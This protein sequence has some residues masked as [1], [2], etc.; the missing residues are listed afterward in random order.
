MKRSE[1]PAFGNMCGIRVI[2]T[3]TNIAGPV[4][5]TFL[6]EQG[7]DV[8]H[9]ESTKSPDMLRRMG[10]AWTQEH[11]NVRSLALNIPSPQ[12]RALFLRLLADADVLIEASKAGQYDKWGLSDETLRTMWA[13]PPLIPSARH[14]AALWGS[15]ERRICPTRPS[16]TPVTSSARCSRR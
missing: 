15:T 5:G 13:A 4:A 12:G 11:R 1:L 14:S 7:A 6:A 16:P 3:G 10:R 8:I 2:T 9:V